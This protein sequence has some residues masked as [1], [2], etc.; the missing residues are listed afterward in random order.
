[1]LSN[2]TGRAAV[3]TL[4]LFALLLGTLQAGTVTLAG[5][6]SVTVTDVA[7]PIAGPQWQYNFTITDNSIAG[8]AVLDITVTPHIT[9]TSLTTPGG[10][11]AF[12]SAYDPVLGLV[13]FLAGTSSFPSTPLAGFIFD[14]PVPPAAD[15]FALTLFDANTGTSAVGAIQ[16]PVAAAAPEPSTLAFVA[17]GCVALAWRTRRS[18]QL[19]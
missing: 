9:I 14:S 1:M 6:G 8:L 16:G 5:D 17:I 12:T 3:R 19:S 4:S 2:L 13:S 7:T 11:G 10:A 18:A 15:K